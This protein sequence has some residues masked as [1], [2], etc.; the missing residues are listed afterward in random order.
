V[1]SNSV[2]PSSIEREIRIQA[3]I[4]VVWSIVTEP[5]HITRWLSESA[6]L[7]L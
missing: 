2:V 1:V 6:E 4:E 7:D 3:P 5:Q